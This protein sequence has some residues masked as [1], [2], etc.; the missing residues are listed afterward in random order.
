[1]NRSLYSALLYLI[2][3]LLLVYLAVR[4]FKSPDYRSRWN[5][6]FGFKGLQQTDLLLHCVSMGETIA[7]IPLIKQI[8]ANYPHLTITVTTTSP[9]GSAAVLRAFSD[10]VQHCYL[11][12]DLAWCSR[13][14]V[15]QVAPKTCIIMETELWP[16][17]IHYLKCNNS[18]VLLANARLSQ[19]S[20]DAYQKRPHLNLPML[21][22]LDAIAAQSEQAAARFI[23]LGVNKDKVTVCGSLKFE[24]DVA[25]ARIEAAKAVREGWQAEHRPIWVAGS[26]HPGEFELMLQ[27]HQRVMQHYPTAL[28]VMVPRHPEQFDTAVTAVKQANMLV[29]RRSLNDDVTAQTQIV[30]GD[31]MGE[32]LTLY[33]A[34]DQAF[35][36]GTLI[37]GGGHNP[38]EPAAVGLPV[39]VGPHHWDFKEITQLLQNE[40]ALQIVDASEPLAQM[41]I[42]F[43]GNKQAYTIASNAAKKVVADNRGAL[44]KQ[45][46]LVESLINR[47]V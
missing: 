13:R 47:N 7:A 31:T 35:V 22:S 40:G 41:L 5:E 17:L 14:F 23:E 19:K 27:A 32:L 9:T 20:A 21:Q 45:F 44:K 2:L 28:M 3:P 26:V 11:P 12:F 29:A 1:M 39:F 30:V 10:E 37:E 33:A 36:G 24:L 8:Q 38:L 42:E 6:R 25:P 16:N 18:K 4:A 46:A 15:T 43:F 34:G